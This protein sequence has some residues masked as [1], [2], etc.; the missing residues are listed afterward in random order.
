MISEM[1]FFDHVKTVNTYLTWFKETKVAKDRSQGS[2][3]FSRY[4]VA[5]CWPKME[6]RIRHW[7]AAGIICELSSFEIGDDIAWH[8]E[9]PPQDRRGPD[10]KLAKRIQ[11]LHA[12]GAF[13]ETLASCQIPKYEGCPPIQPLLNACQ[14]G[15][16]VYG[17]ATCA[18]FH[19]LLLATLCSYAKA[20]S[21]LSIFQK[22]F[23]DRTNFKKR[24]GYIRLVF[25][26]AYI[27]DAIVHSNALRYHLLTLE[28]GQV[29]HLPDQSR[30]DRYA[31]FAEMYLRVGQARRGLE[32]DDPEQE[33]S[34]DADHARADIR[35][36][37]KL[38][39]HHFT[40]QRILE[41]HCGS[42]PIDKPIQI[43]VLG[44][45]KPQHRLPSWD[46]CMSI[47]KSVISEREP[48]I[49]IDKLIQ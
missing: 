18:A 4:L 41:Q 28:A 10:K 2:F 30:R 40:A 34:R 46:G 38:F 37:M 44:V 45:G 8:A 33:P 13:S 6:R 19:H 31:S 35:S 11:H 21:C 27:L 26:C 25:G 24:A 42:L 14:G 12:L 39:V 20:L 49:P 48:Q 17:Q 3:L 29:L 5:A 43:A 7:S 47:V 22:K 15:S 32:D 16:F 23:A 36:W 9:P 1:S